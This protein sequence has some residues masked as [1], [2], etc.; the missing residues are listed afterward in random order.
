[1]GESYILARL[2]LSAKNAVPWEL[3]YTRGVERKLS[4]L[5][6]DEYFGFPVDACLG[7][8]CDHQAQLAYAKFSANFLVKNPDSN[9]YDDYFAADSGLQRM[10]CQ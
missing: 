7:C 8:F 9:M 6:D 4:T 1:M 3:A 5:K 2:E 10:C